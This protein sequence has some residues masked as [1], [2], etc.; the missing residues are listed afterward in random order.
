LGIIILLSAVLFGVMGGIYL[1]SFWF[2]YI[3]ILVYVGGLMVLFIYVASL[4]ANELI[5]FYK[6]PYVVGGSLVISTIGNQMRINFYDR[7]IILV[8]KLDYSGLYEL[9]GGAN[10]FLILFLGG[11]LLLTLMGVVRIIQLQ[12]GPLRQMN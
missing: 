8:N 2:S 9:Y 5:Y 3:L 6:I 1:G 11:Y 7:E 12:E 10:Y 4:A